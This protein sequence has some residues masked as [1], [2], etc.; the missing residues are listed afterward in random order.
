[1]EKK[2]GYMRISELS[3]LSGV[4]IPKIK[5]Y[6]ERQIVPKAIKANRTSAYYAHQH[7]ERLKLIKKIHHEKKLSVAIIKR[8]IDSVSEIEGNGQMSHPDASQIVRDK[9]IYSSIPI[10]RRKG[11]ERTT[12]T[13]ISKSASI[14]RNTFYQNFENKRE[15]FTECLNRIFFDWRKEA[16][17]EKDLTPIL[18]VIKKMYLA[19][20]KA[21]PE[22]SDMMNIF[23]ASATKYPA[24]FS[25]K[26]EESLNIRIRPIVNDVKKGMKQRLFREVSSE[27]VGI[28]IAGIGDYVCY[29]LTRG[30]LDGPAKAF[31][32]VVDILFNGL[33]R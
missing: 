4:P 12:I 17:R 25:D 14:S 24:I 23:R 2:E 15:L 9:I 6:I 13:D 7:L 8:M 1:M 11:Y 30:K 10:F 27:L 5:Y 32:M 20:F 22:W 26:L 31:E 19:F 28:M 33:K 3:K 16:P 21:Y 18:T 29:Y